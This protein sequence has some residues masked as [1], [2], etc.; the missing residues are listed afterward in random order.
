MAHDRPR[1]PIPYDFLPPAASFTV[2]STDMRHGETLADDHVYAYGNVSPELS[3]SGFPDA[4]RSF[5]VTCYDPDA[6]TGSGF[7]HWVAF[8][9]PA[10][11][12]ALPRAAG[13]DDFAGLPA[14]AKQARND[15]G[16]VG[17]GG[18]APPPGHGPH[19]YIFAVHALDIPQLGLDATAPPAKVGFAMFGHVL[20]RGLLIAPYE[21]RG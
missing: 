4:T 5:A 10:N 11:V 14:G 13:S 7:W 15:Y 16:E 12:T 21:A 20:A 17:F 2:T 9:I 19:R 1:P 6:P 8:D 18:A 3:W